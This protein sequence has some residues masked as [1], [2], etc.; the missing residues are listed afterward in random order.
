MTTRRQFFKLVAGAAALAAVP[1]P[2]KAAREGMRG[3][4]NNI[5]NFY[6]SGNFYSQAPANYKLN[7]TDFYKQKRPAG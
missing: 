1:K 5:V 3:R 2:L 7:S 6:T 4:H